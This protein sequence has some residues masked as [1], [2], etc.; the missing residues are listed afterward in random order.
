MKNTLLQYLRSNPKQLLT[1][2]R[3][4]SQIYKS[5]I[6]CIA[7]LQNLSLRIS[8]LG[9]KR[10]DK[11]D[12]YI[13]KD[14]QNLLNCEKAQLFIF[15][16]H[17]G[18]LYTFNHES[19]KTM[20]KIESECTLIK[21]LINGQDVKQRKILQ[22]EDEANKYIGDLLGFKIENMISAKISNEEKLLGTY[23]CLGRLNFF[24][25]FSFLLIYLQE[26]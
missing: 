3:N 23:S 1:S 19:P 8:N 17:S 15:C 24:L 18:T 14:L 20:I 11:M 9:N 21:E 16:N 2:L 22:K 4:V 25:I 10:I 26:L 5:K 12:E 6:D 7:K 13:E